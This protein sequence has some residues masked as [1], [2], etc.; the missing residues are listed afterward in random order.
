MKDA[1]TAGYVCTG[2]YATE[3]E[4]L[5]IKNEQSMPFAKIL[6]SWPGP[7]KLIHRLALAHGLPE[8]PGYYGFDFRDREFIR[9]PDAEMV[10]PVDQSWPELP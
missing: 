6:G 9:V 8:I 1:S 7:E 10:G 5:E 2:V 4:A 3:A